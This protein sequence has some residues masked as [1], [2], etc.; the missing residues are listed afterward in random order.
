MKKIFSILFISLFIFSCG[1]NLV[2]EVK[3]RYDDGKFKVVEYY[4]KVGDNQELVKV[5]HYYKNGQIRQESNY[6]DGKYDGEQI[7]YHDNGQ[8]KR[9]GNYKDGKKEGKLTYYKTDGSLFCE[10]I[11]ENGKKLNGSFLTYYSD[12]TINKEENY[13]E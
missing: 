12:D 10:G 9:E 6:K 1:D 4:K 11:Y 5:S 7:W 13:K 3:E 8:I 2:E